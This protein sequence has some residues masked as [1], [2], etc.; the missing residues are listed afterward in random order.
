VSSPEW[1]GW[2]ASAILIVT[3]GRQV[4]VQWRDRSSEGVSSWLFIGQITASIGFAI[5]S[6][7]IGNRIFILTNCL[8]ILTA[9]IGQYV[10][11]RNRRA[12]SSES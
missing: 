12:A 4:F 3:L 1:I 5:Y 7:L 2:T 11:W 9:L 6:G 10:S 8:L